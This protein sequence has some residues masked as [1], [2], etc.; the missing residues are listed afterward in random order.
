[1]ER[2]DAYEATDGQP[3]HEATRT[4]AEGGHAEVGAELERLGL[5]T[6]TV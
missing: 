5:T 4:L 6:V 3:L 2:W 1:M